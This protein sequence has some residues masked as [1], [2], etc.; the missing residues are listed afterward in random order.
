MAGKKRNFSEAAESAVFATIAEA[1]AEPETA[2]VQEAVEIAQE[3]AAQEKPKKYKERRTYT[4]EEKA[5]LREE[6]KTAGRKDAGLP[7]INMAFT[8]KAHDYVVTMSRARGETLSQFLNL[9]ILQ[10][11]EEH[12]NLYEQAL[13]FRKRL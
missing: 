5:K 12:K 11:M 7:R 8:P 4:E 9:L 10:H 13:E 6:L 1:T 2:E 3:A